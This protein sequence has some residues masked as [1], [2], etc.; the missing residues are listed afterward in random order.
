MRTA[1]E[2]TVVQLDWVYG[3]TP[4]QKARIAALP[5]RRQSWM[6]Y[7]SKG[8]WRETIQG[9]CCSCFSG[10]MRL[11]EHHAEGQANPYKGPVE[12]RKMQIPRHCTQRVVPHTGIQAV[13][14][15]DFAMHQ[16]QHARLE[17]LR[18]ARNIRSPRLAARA[19][20]DDG[21][22]NVYRRHGNAADRRY[23]RAQRQQQ[24]VFSR[25]LHLGEQD[26]SIKKPPRPSLGFVARRNPF[27]GGMGRDY[28]DC[29]LHTDA[30]D[31]GGVACRTGY[32]RA[33]KASPTGMIA[34]YADRFQD[35]LDAG[36]WR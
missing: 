3:I 19:G 31:K 32:D 34:G 27:R 21:F 2:Q 15:Y 14:R 17:E 28:W 18:W 36:G 6:F 9:R 23:L 1:C 26:C 8:A 5:N 11:R 4:Y 10:K 35:A 22:G 16:A 24:R 7:R 20:W 13:A 29:L 33:S 25:K 12:L 30:P